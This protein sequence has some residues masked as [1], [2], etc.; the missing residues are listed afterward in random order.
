MLSNFHKTVHSTETDRTDYRFPFK[1]L[2]AHDLRVSLVDPA[3]HEQVPLFL[4]A[5]YQVTGVGDDAGGQVELTLLGVKKAEEGLKIVLKRGQAY[6]CT[7]G[8]STPVFAGGNLS[9]SEET[10]GIDY[11]DGNRVIYQKTIAFGAL[12]TAGPSKMVP[13]NTPNMRRYWVERSW[14][15]SPNVSNGNCH[16][17]PIANGA[18]NQQVAIAMN[19]ETVHMQAWTDYWAANYPKS[20][21][22]IRYTKD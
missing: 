5:D 7:G 14:A 12:P 9:E 22:T 10:V 6:E 19:R 17:I 20:W 3:D 16:L 4:G 1:V 15:V 8:G 13:H 18:P 21:V 2:D 11:T